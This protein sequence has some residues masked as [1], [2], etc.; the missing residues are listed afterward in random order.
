VFGS[1]AGGPRLSSPPGV[2]GPSSTPAMPP[3]PP[4]TA[5]G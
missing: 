4:G 1:S 3:G 5:G 2:P